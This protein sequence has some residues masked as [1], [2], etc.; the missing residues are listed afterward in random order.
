[1]PP[2]QELLHHETYKSKK[3]RWTLHLHCQAAR[4]NGSK[5]TLMLLCV[6]WELKQ[7]VGDVETVCCFV[8]VPAGH[9][10]IIHFQ[11]N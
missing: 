6:S 5:A 2:P 4:I 3:G 7:A 9:N 11:D 1:M 10:R 8:S